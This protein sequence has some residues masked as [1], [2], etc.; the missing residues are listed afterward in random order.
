MNAEK[1]RIQQ[2]MEEGAYNMM[3]VPGPG[4]PDTVEELSMLMREKV[5]LTKTLHN[6]KMK[7]QDLSA[8]SESIKAR[9]AEVEQG[10]Q[11]QAQMFDQE[12]NWR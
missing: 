5:D 6:V 10:I 7:Q 2:A 1:G 8:Q 12:T 11:K 3:D 9:L 4:R